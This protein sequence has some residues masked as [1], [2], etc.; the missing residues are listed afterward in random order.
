[1][2]GMRYL[3]A[4]GMTETVKGIFPHSSFAYMTQGCYVSF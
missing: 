1:M 4:A 2:S 3:P